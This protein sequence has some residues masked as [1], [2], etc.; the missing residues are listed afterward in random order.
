MIVSSALSHTLCSSVLKFVK[1]LPRAWLLQLLA[2]ATTDV[3]SLEQTSLVCCASSTVVTFALTAARS[4]RNLNIC[5]ANATPLLG[6]AWP[7]H[8]LA[9]CSQ[10]ANNP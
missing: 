8:F 4:D 5:S 3:S 7:G 9:A 1:S 10:S 2:K 6:S